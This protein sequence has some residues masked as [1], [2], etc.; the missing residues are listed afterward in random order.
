MLTIKIKLQ[1]SLKRRLV[2]LK[3]LNKTNELLF[4]IKIKYLNLVNK[5]YFQ[6]KHIGIYTDTK[7]KQHILSQRGDFL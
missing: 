2:L 5:I 7:I 3:I 6:C 4:S 1:Y